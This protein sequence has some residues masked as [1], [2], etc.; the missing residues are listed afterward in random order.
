M[1]AE[2][3]TRVRSVTLPDFRLVFESIPG[4][5][6]VL[7][8]DD[9][10]FT[11]VAVTNIY[12][13]NTATTREQLIG[14]GLF[15]ILPGIRD[16]ANAVSDLRA[17]LHRVL[18]SKTR[19]SMLIQK[20]EVPRPES[21]GGV[22]EERYWSP[23]NTPVIGENGEVEYIIHRVEDVTDYVR[24]KD[25]ESAQRE[26]TRNL[27]ERE[28]EA[29]FRAELLNRIGPVLVSELHTDRLVQKATDLA[30]QL[31]GADFGALFHSELC[32][33]TS[34]ATRANRTPSTLFRARLA[35][36][37]IDFRCRETQ[38]Y[39]DQPFAAIRWFAAMT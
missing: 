2:R 21:E 4:P 28:T 32:S 36:C 35:S 7:L 5:T 12:L 9:P 37:L 27:L 1:A 3:K 30:T 33:I 34:S 11:I 29:R 16:D 6:L 38:R 18:M 26:L 23:V 24:I 22:S 39:S 31:T 14:R 25:A 20:Y 10:I 17:S 15:E 8:P 19:H 13:Q